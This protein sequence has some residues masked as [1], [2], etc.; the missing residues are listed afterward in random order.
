MKTL[1]A[2]PCMDMVPVGFVQSLLHL[3][4]GQDVSVL[5][6]A[7][8]LVYDSRNLICLTAIEHGFDR[9]MWFDSD[10]M[11]TPATMRI[12]QADMDGRSSIGGAN[13]SDFPGCDMVTGL[14]FRRHTPHTPVI[15]RELKE[16]A[17]DESGQLVGRIKEY[18]ANYPKDT[19]F[20]IS[21]CGMG[22]CMTSVKLLKDVWDHFG[23]AFSPFPWAGEDY[24]FCHRV[25]QLGYHIWCDSRVSCGHIGQY[26]YTEENCTATRKG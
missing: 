19:L 14:Y 5:F 12:L 16:P 10:M 21:G 20:T 8:S 26:V 15:L 9:V 24:S 22:C 23:P 25:N 2:I 4:K 3:E 6:K 11:F 13:L 18:D 7:S 1:I 17:Q